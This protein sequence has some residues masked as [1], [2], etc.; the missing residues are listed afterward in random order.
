MITGSL[1]NFLGIGAQRSGTSWLYF[2][3]KSHPEI[4]VPPHAKEVHFF[5]RYY[6]RGLDW[7][8]SFFASEGVKGSHKARGEI[9][10][11]YLF[12]EAVPTRVREHLPHAKFIVL[13]RNPV[14]R[15]Y[16]N[17]RN[18]YFKG[19]TNAESFSHFI[20]DTPS[21]FMRGMYAAQIRRW[22]DHFPRDRFLILIFEEVFRNPVEATQLIASF[23]GVAPQGFD[24]EAL[25]QKVNPSN[26]PR[27][28]ALYQFGIRVRRY[29]QRKDFHRTGRL[30]EEVGSRFFR[31]LGESKRRVPALYEADRRRLLDA[32]AQDI[33]ELETMLERDLSVWQEDETIHGCQ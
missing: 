31:L 7:Y 5:D 8:G 3:L 10:P 16:S 1:P 30:L 9:S 13:L 15:A 19:L 21:V 2:L 25:E 6:D 32:Y 33:E 27:V 17:F 23:L 24:K 4:F 26:A 20:Q 28:P 18:V 12:D 29:L 22:F 11:A 14:N